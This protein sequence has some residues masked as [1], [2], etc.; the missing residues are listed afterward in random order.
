MIKPG[1][2]ELV[3]RARRLADWGRL[4][5]WETGFV[6]GIAAKARRPAWRPSARQLEVLERI[7][8]PDVGSPLIDEGDAPELIE[9][10]E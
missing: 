10:G 8:A 3:F 4:T 7:V 1:F 5:E 2:D 9:G 6:R